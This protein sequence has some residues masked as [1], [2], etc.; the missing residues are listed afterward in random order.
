MEE[1]VLTGSEKLAEYNSKAAVSVG[2]SGPHKE[3]LA[4]N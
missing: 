4:E 3:Y 1:K 2:Q